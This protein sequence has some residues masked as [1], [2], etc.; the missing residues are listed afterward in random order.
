MKVTLQDVARAAGVSPATVSRVLAGHAARFY[1]PSTRQRIKEAA[2]RL[3]YRPSFAARAL[4]TGRT[5]LV[6]LWSYHPYQAFFAAIMEGMQK[7]A[8]E[9]GYGLLVA[10]AAVR[11]TDEYGSNAAVWSC[12]GILAMDC[13]EFAQRVL[14]SRPSKD[15]PIVSIGTTLVPETD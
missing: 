6:T 2:K 13:G 5:S 15:T 3:G 4:A 11:D 12:D 1:V 10:D 9:R 14:Q 8:Q 7:Q